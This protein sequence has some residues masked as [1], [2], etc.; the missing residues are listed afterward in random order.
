L[1]DLE[2][3]MMNAGKVTTVRVY[4]DRAAVTRTR[5]FEALGNMREVEFSPLPLTIDASTLRAR[6][7]A[8]QKSGAEL[9]VRVNGVSATLIYAEV[10]NERQKAIVEEM[11]DVESKMNGIEDAEGTDTHV[12]G[13]LEKYAAVATATISREWLE[14]TPSFDKWSE[15]FD[16][17]RK[18]TEKF[19]VRTAM[20]K[21]EKQKLVQK[22]AD[23][24]EEETRIG[25][26]ERSGYRAKVA[27]EPPP[28]DT[29]ELVV[30]LTYVTRAAQWMPIYDAR[31]EG[32]KLRL[33]SIALVRQGT[34]E[35]WNDV[36]LIATTA[37]PPLSEPLPELAAITVRGHAR[38]EQR[39]IVST[40]ELE[41][42]LG[43]VAEKRLDAG[44]AEV[45]FR[46]PGKV[47]VPA[48]NHP[49]RVELFEV[50]LPSR[51]RLETS[52][53]A[54]PV[55]LLVAD[56]ENQSGRVLLPGRV[57]VF[58]GA[59]YAGQTELGF[60]SA[61]ERFRIPLGSDASVRIRREARAL[62]EKQAMITGSTTH[63]YSCRTT[64]ENLSS[65]P[66]ELVVR[67]RL[68]V[69]RADEAVVRIGEI[70][71]GVKIDDESGVYAVEVRL[72]PREKR[73]LMTAFSIT[74]PRGYKLRAPAGFE[75]S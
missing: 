56:V 27:I 51:A 13:L 26:P 50:E 31:L 70:E 43:G 61:G 75:A 7:I 29:V 6:V 40:G 67:D 72:A 69:S 24:L 48:T 53:M 14:R 17:L 30:E 64:L 46:A 39:T 66:I 12:A 16:H 33:T 62:P 1:I 54:R 37:R 34:G 38:T 58:R 59:A 10:E 20:R 74:A 45:E 63:A 11:R 18:A 65:S 41:P 3:R 47:T 55:A 52:P 21:L 19:S 25:R 8:R 73:E 36:E 42:R 44:D 49:M 68:P 32:E 28:A 4:I 22:R 71:R 57:N 35:D 2:D 5:A 60:I 23:L 15:A 9:R